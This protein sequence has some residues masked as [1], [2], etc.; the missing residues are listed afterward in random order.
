MIRLNEPFTNDEREPYRYFSLMVGAAKSSFLPV[1]IDE[2]NYI[3]RGLLESESGNFHRAFLSYENEKRRVRIMI[4]LKLSAGLSEQQR[5]ILGQLQHSSEMS[6]FDWDQEHRQLTLRASSVCSR[7]ERPSFTIKQILEDVLSVLSDDRLE[8]VI[9]N[10][11][12]KGSLSK[13][14]QVAL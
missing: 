6:R 13:E 2:A 5:E 9:G 3:A 8:A 11:E 4:V 7:P 1:T 10:Q 14:R 12:F